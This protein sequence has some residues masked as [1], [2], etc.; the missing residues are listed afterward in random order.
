M[1]YIVKDVDGG[2]LTACISI[3]IFLFFIVANICNVYSEDTDPVIDQVIV[4]GNKKI[5]KNIIATIFVGLISYWFLIFF[6]FLFK[7]IFGACHHL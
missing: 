3:F 5:S 1:H 4:I 7:N 2:K 6:Y